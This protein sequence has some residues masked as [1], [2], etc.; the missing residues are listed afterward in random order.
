MLL[1]VLKLFLM[2]TPHVSLHQEVADWVRDLIFDGQLVPGTYIDEREMC[3]RYAISRTPLREALKVLCAEGLLVHEPRVG[4][5]V[6][7]ITREDLNEIFPMVSLLEGRSAY[8]ATLRLKP[9]DLE[10]LRI[11]QSRL[12]EAFK[13]QD[14]AAYY[15]VNLA[16]HEAIISLS[17]N[18]WLTQ[19]IL[20]LRKILRLSRL[21][22][23]HAP[24]RFE[25][26]YHE[27][28]KIFECLLK[29]D[30]LA[31]QEA[32]REHINHQHAALTELADL[33]LRTVSV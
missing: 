23:L 5:S 10:A 22:Q 8:E 4:C 17:S 3:A 21:Q 2:K 14:I 9:A 11:W 7:V 26:S 27:H 12:E 25:Q 1:T 29:R 19:T 33:T 15:R 32:M 30:A 6:R 18:A 28:Q 20:D 24:G 13:A 16:L 31:A